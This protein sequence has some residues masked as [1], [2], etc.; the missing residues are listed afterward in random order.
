M[1]KALLFTFAALFALFTA[2]NAQQRSPEERAKQETES[3]KTALN[4]TD[5]Q[6][7]QVD[8]INLKYALKRREMFQQ[9]QGSDPAE[10]E[11]LRNEID[12]LKRAELEKILTADQLTKYDAMVAERRQNRPGPP[13]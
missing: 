12:N 1:K 8:S 9:S 5:N 3:M 13:M 7:I 11:K 4:L 6:L 10:R 2:A